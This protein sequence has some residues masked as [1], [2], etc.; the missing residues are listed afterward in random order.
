MCVCGSLTCHGQL[1][2][3]VLHKFEG[4][5]YSSWWANYEHLKLVNWLGS[6]RSGAQ[7]E[8]GLA[9]C[10]KDYDGAMVRAFRQLVAKELLD[11]PDMVLGRV[12]GL[13]DTAITLAGASGDLVKVLQYD[14]MFV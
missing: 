6:V 13:E 1:L 7:F 2:L 9:D 8:A 3:A 12:G 10:S 5:Q 11:K 4:V 14:I